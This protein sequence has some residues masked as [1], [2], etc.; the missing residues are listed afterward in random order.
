MLFSG[1]SLPLSPSDHQIVGDENFD[2][3]MT[4]G[5]GQDFPDGCSSINGEDVSDDYSFD[6]G[7]S[8]IANLRSGQ[9]SIAARSSGQNSNA[10]CPSGQ[11]ALQVVPVTGE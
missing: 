9:S 11:R 7:E 5:S 8:S 3:D 2:A 10:G 1:I 6:R 4:G